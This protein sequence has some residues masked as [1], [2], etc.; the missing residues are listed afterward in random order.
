MLDPRERVLKILADLL[1]AEQKLY[2]RPDKAYLRIIALDKY[3]ELRRYVR[4]IYNV[5]IFCEEKD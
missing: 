5:D 3:K 1:E 4:L 2:L